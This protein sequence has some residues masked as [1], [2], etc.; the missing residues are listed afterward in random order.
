MFVLPVYSTFLELCLL[1]GLFFSKIKVLFPK[2]LILVHQKRDRVLI[3]FKTHLEGRNPST[4]WETTVL[5]ALH[6]RA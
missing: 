1:R 6:N 5:K 3:E 2:E 4:E